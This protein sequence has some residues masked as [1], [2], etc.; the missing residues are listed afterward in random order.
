[1]IGM[2]SRKYLAVM[3]ISFRLYSLFVLSGN[4]F[5]VLNRPHVYIWIGLSI[6]SDNQMLQAQTNLPYFLITAPTHPFPLIYFQ[7][8]LIV[9]CSSAPQRQVTHK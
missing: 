7:N 2:K 8:L 6:L 3:L 5:S 9:P 1:M 4:K